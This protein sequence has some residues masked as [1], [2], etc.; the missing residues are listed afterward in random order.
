MRG[1]VLGATAGAAVTF[2][3]A[4]FLPW[5]ADTSAFGLIGHGLTT[6]GEFTFEAPGAGT[7]LELAVFGLVGAAAIVAALLAACRT[8]AVTAVVAAAI[9]VHLALRDHP[10]LPSGPGP[11][12]ATVAMTVLAV[13]QVAAIWRPTTGWWSAIAGLAVAAVLAVAAGLGGA[14]FAAARDVDITTSG[15]HAPVVLAQQEGALSGITARDAVTGAQRWHHWERGWTS[16]F[17]GLSPDGGVAYL[18]VGAVGERD[19]LAFVAAT[20]EPLWR[21][22]LGPSEWVADVTPPGPGIYGQRYL[23]VGPGLVVGEADG[24]L[25]YLDQDGREGTIGLD[26]GCGVIG[27][28]GTEHLYLVEACVGVVRVLAVDRNTNRLWSTTAFQPVSDATQA[29]V[30]DKGDSIVV[31]VNGLTATL[32]AVHGRLRG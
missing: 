32:D 28:D 24:R 23:P 9:G 10:G 29:T 6:R 1:V 3:T 8:S 11:V 22:R 20:G 18:E 27:V 14:A 21:K 31:T 4:W 13:A 25:R 17:V 30:D 19:A 16:P 15:A 5:M 7:A 2:V 26:G 12:I